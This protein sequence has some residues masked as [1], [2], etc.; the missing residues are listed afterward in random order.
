[1]V[2]WVHEHAIVQL[3]SRLV[4]QFVG[5]KPNKHIRRHDGHQLMEIPKFRFYQLRL[6]EVDVLRVIANAIE[7]QAC[8]EP[9][10]YSD[11]FKIVIKF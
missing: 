4:V 3:V 8:Q 6:Q 1:M 7:H 2:F 11:L 5:R 10:I 9:S